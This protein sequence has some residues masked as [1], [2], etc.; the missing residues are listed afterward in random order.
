MTPARL[1]DVDVGA[2]VELA[3]VDAVAAAVARQEHQLL[4]VEGPEQQLVRGLP[5]GR[6]DSPPLGILEPG[7]VVDAAAADH[8]DDRRGSSLGQFGHPVAA[9]SLFPRGVTKP[10]PARRHDGRIARACQEVRCTEA[11]SGSG[12]RFGGAVRGGGS[13]GRFGMA[14][15]PGYW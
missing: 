8:A 14:A 6:L 13:G 9:V 12:G 10:A 11:V 3:R 5:E 4:A 15:Q 2:E 7:D 1:S